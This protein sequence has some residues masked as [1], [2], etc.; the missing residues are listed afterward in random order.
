V[1]APL[2]KAKKQLAILGSSAPR[3]VFELSGGRMFST[4]HS[5]EQESTFLAQ[6][7]SD[8]GLK[9]V[10]IVFLE[11]Q[12]SRAH[13]KAFRDHFRGDVAETLAYGGSDLS[14]LKLTALRVRR[15]DVEALFVPD[16]FPLMQGLMK[17][18]AGQGLR[19]LKVYSVYSAQSEDVLKAMG[20]EGEG[21]I[22]SYPAIG[23]ADALDYFPA[24]AA[25]IMKRVVA[26]CGNDPECGLRLLRKEYKFD[27]YGVLEGELLLKTVSNGA[28]QELKE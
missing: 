12:F 3:N 5:I 10:A 23:S 9:R 28:F 27:Q 6:K 14:E 7:L 20:P 2:L 18:L 21:L 17:E 4:Q 16:A 26:E 1:V 15:L 25:R 13:E 22:Y 24:L 19:N 11:N 8:A